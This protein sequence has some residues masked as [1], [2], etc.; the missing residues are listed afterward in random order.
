MICVL[1]VYGGQETGEADLNPIYMFI[2]WGFFSAQK[3]QML[4]LAIRKT[5]TW[6]GELLMKIGKKSSRCSLLLC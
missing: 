6:I 3:M 4:L 5:Y 2:L 1:T